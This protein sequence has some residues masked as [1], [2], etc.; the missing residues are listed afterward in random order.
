MSMKVPDSHLNQRNP[1][2]DKNP[3]WPAAKIIYGERERERERERDRER[4]RKR[5]NI[6][7]NTNT[8]IQDISKLQQAQ[9]NITN[10]NIYTKRL[11]ITTIKKYRQI[12]TI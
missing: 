1:T 10:C 5:E 7:T 11:Q 8:Y 2:Q 3:P 12:Y 4:D 6:A 9:S